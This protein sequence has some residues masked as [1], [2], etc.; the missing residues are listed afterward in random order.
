MI[1]LIGLLHTIIINIL[2][3]PK[4]LEHVHSG[5]KSVLDETISQSQPQFPV[6][7]HWS[8]KTG[9]QS[10]KASE[11]QYFCVLSRHIRF[12][13]CPIQLFFPYEVPCSYD[14]SKI[15]I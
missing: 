2:Y 12:I 10:T 3:L 11:S 9:R 14:S 5:L 13:F 15:V 8:R 7:F 4:R 1:L 6:V